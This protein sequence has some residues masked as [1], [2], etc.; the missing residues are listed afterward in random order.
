MYVSTF[1]MP[2]VKY[3]IAMKGYKISDY[4]LQEYRLN[5][6]FRLLTLKAIYECVAF[7]EVTPLGQFT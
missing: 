1:E 6:T 7:H 5:S 3:E 4:Y 2:C